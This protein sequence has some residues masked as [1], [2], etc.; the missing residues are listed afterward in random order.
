MKTTN[1]RTKTAQIAVNVLTSANLRLAATHQ[2]F[3]RKS[4]IDSISH[5]WPFS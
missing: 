1:A 2:L 5:L 4:S 3:A